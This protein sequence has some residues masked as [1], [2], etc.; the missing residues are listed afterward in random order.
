MEISYGKRGRLSHAERQQCC[1]PGNVY[2][3]QMV[4]GTS[5]APLTGLREEAARTVVALLNSVSLEFSMTFD[6][7]QEIVLANAFRLTKR[8]PKL[9]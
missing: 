2:K 6:A 8:R 9:P 1:L 4:P 7:H 5:T 3:G